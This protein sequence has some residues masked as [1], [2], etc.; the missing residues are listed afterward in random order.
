MITT[1]SNSFTEF[2]ILLE[3]VSLLMD[4]VPTLVL[5]LLCLLDLLPMQVAKVLTSNTNTSTAGNETLTT[6]HV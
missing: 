5:M 6:F 4:I 3:S 2:P 1:Y